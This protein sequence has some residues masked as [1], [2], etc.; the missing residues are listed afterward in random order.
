MN[1]MLHIITALLHKGQEFMPVIFGFCLVSVMISFVA[2]I[3]L[4]RIYSKKFLYG[5]SIIGLAV[6]MPLLYFLGEKSILGIPALP[7]AYVLFFLIGLPMAGMMSMQTPILADIADCDEKQTGHRREAMFFGAQGFLQKFAIAA[8][9]LI[10]GY[11]FSHYGYSVKNPMGVRLLGPVTGAFV[12]I[13][14]IVI[15]FYNLDEKTKTIR[16]KAKTMAL[17]YVMS[18]FI[19]F[20]GIPIGAR[21]LKSQNVDERRYAFRCLALGILG[22]IAYSVFAYLKISKTI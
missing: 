21:F 10:Q 18:F 14:F 15:L 5:A 4:Q 22:A 6:V 8:T 20:L 9:S 13:G 16:G 3:Y 11:L 12:F 7:V 17:L 19:P 1:S 2:I